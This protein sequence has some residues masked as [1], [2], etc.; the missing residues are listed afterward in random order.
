MTKEGPRSSYYGQLREFNPVV[1]DWTVYKRRMDNY[2]IVNAITDDNFKRAMLLTA[3]DEEA[4]KLI[5][6]LCLPTAPEDKSFTELTELFD[7][8]FKTCESAFVARQRFYAATRNSQESAA[9]FAARLRGL[10]CKGEFPEAVLDM[11]LRDRFIMG[12][13]KGPVQDRLFE[14]KISVSFADAVSVASRKMATHSLQQQVQ[15]K[16]EPEVLKVSQGKGSSRFKPQFKPSVTPGAQKSAKGEVKSLQR[17]KVCGRG[18]HMAQD[19]RFK[20]YKCHVCGVQGHLAPV[21]SRKRDGHRVQNY[22]E[23]QDESIFCIKSDGLKPIYLPI[24]IFNKQFS[25]QLDSGASVSVVSEEFW[26]SNLEEVALEPSKR[27]LFV[28][29]GAKLDTI[30]CCQIPI[31]YNNV[32]K[33]IESFVVRNGRVPILG[34]DFMKLYSKY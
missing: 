14:E 7:K 34:R 28:Y 15:V 6:N 5:F 18:N 16:L 20:D 32:V 22:M 17:C 2:F 26:Q 23:D 24:T 9:E 11:T 19:C 1:S 31:E 3:L 12:F 10:A 8:H 21:C 4:Y 25:F 33:E 27:N 29:H 13:G 30:G